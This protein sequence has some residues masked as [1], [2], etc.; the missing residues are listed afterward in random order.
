MA[1]G[2]VTSGTRGRYHGVSVDWRWKERL[3]RCSTVTVVLSVP[4][5]ASASTAGRS[6]CSVCSVCGGPNLPEI[7]E[8]K[9]GTSSQHQKL[10]GSSFMVIRG[11]DSRHVMCCVCVRSCVC[12]SS[13]M[14]VHCCNSL[15]FVCSS[16]CKPRLSGITVGTRER[17]GN[18]IRA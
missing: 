5:T 18:E 11:R 8:S 16:A 13:G 7:S 4:A 1:G 10:V 9:S 14:T 12:V 6:V 17:I 2:I 15:L 3:R